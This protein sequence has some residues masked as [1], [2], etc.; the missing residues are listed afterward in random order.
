MYA[1]AFGER[2]QVL[3][4]YC[5]MPYLRHFHMQNLNVIAARMRRY[6]PTESI[7]YDNLIK[8][9]LK[10]NS[11]TIKSLVDHQMLPLGHEFDHICYLYCK[12]NIQM[13][14]ENQPLDNRMEVKLCQNK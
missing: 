10:K 2:G 4:S 5:G 7:Y 1:P 13:D 6:V 3:H 9:M 8:K 12:G 14:V 11:F